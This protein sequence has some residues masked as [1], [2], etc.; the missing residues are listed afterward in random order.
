MATLRKKY[1]TNETI[2]KRVL[3]ESGI[4]R[5]ASSKR[6]FSK[7]Q[8][9]DIVSEYNAGASFKKLRKKYNTN[10]KTIIR[11]LKESGVILRNPFSK[12]GRDQ[13]IIEDYKAGLAI[14]KIAKKN[15]TNKRIVY[16]VLQESGT[17]ERDPGVKIRNTRPA[18]LD[19]SKIIA[20]YEA[21]IPISQLAKKY[22]TG[23]Q[24]IKGILREAH[25]GDNKAQAVISLAKRGIPIE[26]IAA[27]MK[28]PKQKVRQLIKDAG[29]ADLI[30]EGLAS[31]AAGKR[32]PA[33]VKNNIMGLVNRNP[34]VLTMRARTMMVYY[35]NHTPQET[36]EKFGLTIEELDYNVTKMLDS[37][38]EA[39]KKRVAKIKT[40]PPRR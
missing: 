1:K 25:V 5:R 23:H 36:A 33:E 15:K 29:F 8:I 32:G 9:K 19:A 37:L 38:N 3:D 20:D 6:E 11:I 17:N 31:D 27:Q 40:K 7:N 13:Q 2:I 30:V 22:G 21:G 4:E 28:M 26:K 39:D 35:S 12:P 34:S 16:R 10:E 24:R 14:A 18:K